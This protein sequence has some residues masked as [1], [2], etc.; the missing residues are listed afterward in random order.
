MGSSEGTAASPVFSLKEE[1]V[2]MIVRLSVA[3]PAGRAGEEEG[4]V[5]L[6]GGG[7]EAGRAIR[8]WPGMAMQVVAGGE[9]GRAAGSGGGSSADAMRR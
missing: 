4:L 5:R 9:G 3:W 1:L 2:G 6:L 8:A 7:V